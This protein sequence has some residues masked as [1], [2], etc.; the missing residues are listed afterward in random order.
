MA[1]NQNKNIISIEK[2]KMRK[3][4]GTETEEK[5]KTCNKKNS[6]MSKHAGFCWEVFIC[7]VFI[8]THKQMLQFII[9]LK[10]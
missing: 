7:T 9:R 10:V 2:S 8:R 3:N 5:Y 6:L 1:I 4:H